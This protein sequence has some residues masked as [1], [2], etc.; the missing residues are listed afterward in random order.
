MDQDGEIVD[1]YLQVHRDGAAVNRFFQ[2]LLRNHG[3]EPRKIVTDKL[4]SYRVAHREVIPES[5]HVTEQYAVYNLINLGRHLVSAGHYRSL[6]T[7][8][9]SEWSRA[10]A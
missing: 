3:G 10:V 1:V 5:I 8:A 4:G 9:F 6:R 2:R 7:S